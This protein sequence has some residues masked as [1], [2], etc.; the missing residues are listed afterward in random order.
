MQQKEVTKE[1]AQCHV[2]EA[3]P[4]GNEGM[5]LARQRVSLN[6]CS[7]PKKKRYIHITQI[8]RSCRWHSSFNVFQT[9]SFG[10]KYHHFPDF[11]IL[12]F[13]NKITVV[14]MVLEMMMITNKLNVLVVLF[15]RDLSFDQF[16]CHWNHLYSLI[17]ALIS[18]NQTPSKYFRL[19]GFVKR[20]NVKNAWLCTTP[21]SGNLSS[22]V[23]FRINLLYNTDLK[24][25]RY[26]PKH[27]KM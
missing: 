14:R 3:G 9:G 26:N 27:K 10:K 20:T 18:S 15:L 8:E 24:S 25:N 16:S 7:N 23:K 22:P 1:K 4:Q 5:R 19:F 13:C 17:L 12:V 21:R 6:G 11:T 2:C